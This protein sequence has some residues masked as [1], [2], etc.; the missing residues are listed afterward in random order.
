M[1]QSKQI[2]LWIWEN[3]K[4]LR[5]RY[6]SWKDAARVASQSLGFT[7]SSVRLRRKAGECGY[8]GSRYPIIGRRTKFDGKEWNEMILWC[9]TH[10]HEIGRYM[11]TFEQVARAM[12]DRTSLC[13]SAHAAKE[14]M[15]TAKCS[16]L[17]C[18]EQ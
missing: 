9:V 14:A 8:C 12:S 6:S 1:I 10:S 16:P 15:H 17:C 11:K 13:V 2:D 4:W 7:V 18:E 3:A 5:Y